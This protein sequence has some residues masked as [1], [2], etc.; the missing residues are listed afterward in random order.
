MRAGS[1]T[2]MQLQDKVSGPYLA[3]DQA[4]FDCNPTVSIQV[5]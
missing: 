4:V 1:D 2:P 5:E 3:A